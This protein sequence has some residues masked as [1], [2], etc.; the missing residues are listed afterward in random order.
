MEKEKEI[1]SGE[2]FLKVQKCVKK[3]WRKNKG[4]PLEIKY[5]QIAEIW[6]LVFWIF[7]QD[8]FWNIFWNI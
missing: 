3:K 7:K 2:K 1:S 6:W 4:F 5:S 8:K